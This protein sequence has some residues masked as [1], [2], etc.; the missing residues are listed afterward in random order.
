M[1]FLVAMSLMAVAVSAAARG[2]ESVAVRRG[3][4][5][6]LLYVAASTR[7]MPVLGVP[8][9]Y[10]GAWEAKHHIDAFSHELKL[11]VSERSDLLHDYIELLHNRE[12]DLARLT[13]E[14]YEEMAR[15]ASQY[16]AERKAS[17]LGRFKWSWMD[18]EYA[19]LAKLNDE[20]RKQILQQALQISA[21]RQHQLRSRQRGNSFIADAHKILLARTDGYRQSDSDLFAFYEA[22]PMLNTPLLESEMALVRKMLVETDLSNGH[23]LDKLELAMLKSLKEDKAIE[24]QDKVHL[25]DIFSHATLTKMTKKYYSVG[26]Q[27]YVEHPDFAAQMIEFN[28]SHARNNITLQT[29]AMRKEWHVTWAQLREK[30][31]VVAALGELR[32]ALGFDW[33]SLGK[34]IYP[35]DEL[36]AAQLIT[37]AKEDNEIEPVVTALQ[38]HRETLQNDELVT[39]IDTLIA[40]LPHLVEKDELLSDIIQLLQNGWLTEDTQ[41]YAEL[42]GTSPRA[43]LLEAVEQA[44]N[45]LGRW[46]Y[47]SP[48]RIQKHSWYIAST[49]LAARLTELGLTETQLREQVFTSAGFA[50]LQHGTAFDA[51]EIEA[52]RQLVSAEKINN[53]LRSYTGDDKKI[54][55]QQI[56]YLPL[57]LQLESFVLTLGKRIN[58]DGEFVQALEALRTESNMFSPLA[59]MLQQLHKPRTTAS[60]N[61]RRRKGKTP[62]QLR[63]VRTA[64]VKIA[65]EMGVVQHKHFVVKKTQPDRKMTEQREKKR[66]Q[67]RQLQIKRTAEQQAQ[68]EL[69][70]DVASLANKIGRK[71][72]PFNTPIW[73]RLRAI[74]VYAELS[75]TALVQLAEMQAVGAKRFAV[76]I[77]PDDGAM[78]TKAELDNIK[79]A[80]I[81]HTL[82]REKRHIIS[83]KQKDRLLENIEIEVEAILKLL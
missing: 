16:V 50:K 57:I 66:E 22:F 38:A 25:A 4:A 72:I 13:T 18:Y 10:D 55:T 77:S 42:E 34:L 7:I 36:A 21:R 82:K 78:P 29:I 17:Y 71:A 12:V 31:T 15:V 65:E 5:A 8:I 75:G 53:L 70:Q 6:D 64:L 52:V 62:S 73:L 40:D 37:S 43:I 56:Q 46:H 63:Q 39:H 14:L 49:V 11:V 79:Q 2:L 59:L 69:E 41:P 48:V 35:Q 3:T 24:L 28:L 19:D 20:R 44:T 1:K 58:S 51:Q 83:S 60:K 68:R 47:L 26:R 74:L 33:P 23:I 32:Q 67:Q 30:R 81:K 76:L 9:T 80:L 61:K 54:I 45:D 27:T